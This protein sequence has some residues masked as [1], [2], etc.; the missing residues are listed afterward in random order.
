MVLFP[1]GCLERFFCNM[2]KS[3]LLV[4]YWRVI[5]FWFL[6]AVCQ[7]SQIWQGSPDE[8][9]P[10]GSVLVLPL[11]TY[12]LLQHFCLNKLYILRDSWS[13]GDIFR[14]NCLVQPRGLP[15]SK[16]RFQVLVRFLAMMTSSIKIQGTIY[17]TQLSI[18]CSNC[19]KFCAHFSTFSL[20]AYDF[21]KYFRTY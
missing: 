8:I 14:M 17:I 6:N 20:T 12:F 18:A 7:G 11:D 3:A 10:N 5:N 16:A 4:S 19:L 2:I 1:V 21:H 13:E 15:K 9:F